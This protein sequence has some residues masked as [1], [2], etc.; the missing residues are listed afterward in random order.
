MFAGL[1]STALLSVL[2]A[3]GFLPAVAAPGADFIPL[4][5]AQSA[6]LGVV[7]RP[8]DAPGNAAA[9]GLPAIIGIP[10]AQQ[11]VIAAPLA[12]V[13]E[14][15]ETAPGMTVKK[16]Q[17]LARISSP[18]ALELQRDRIQADSQ[19]TLARQT[20]SAA[21]NNSFAKA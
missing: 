9:I 4:T 5:P 14:S 13:V 3:P 11:R 6:A 12:G 15:L 19:A 7:T 1:R 18:Q 21:T 20:Q 8:L 10:N 2:I 17:V 16:G